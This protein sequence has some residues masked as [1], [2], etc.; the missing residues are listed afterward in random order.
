[1]P[2][3]YDIHKGKDLGRVQNMKIFK[4]ST[5]QCLINFTFFY[6]LF[7]PVLDTFVLPT[8]PVHIFGE[9]VGYNL[10]PRSTDVVSFPV[11]NVFVSA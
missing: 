1:M 10:R 11:F 6:S 3:T 7:S 4:D 5:F 2:A 8:Q 9:V